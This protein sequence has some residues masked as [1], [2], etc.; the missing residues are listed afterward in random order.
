MGKI[1]LEWTIFMVHEWEQTMCT[2]HKWDWTIQRYAYFK[3]LIR[4]DWEMTKNEWENILH[5][6]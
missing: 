2:V 6:C 1:E 4:N 3:D 5:D